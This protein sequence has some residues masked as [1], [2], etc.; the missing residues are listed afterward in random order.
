MA[1]F[2]FNA[3]DVP[4]DEYEL[5]PKGEYVALITDSEIKDTK[6][7]KMLVLTFNICEGA[8]KGRI[9]IERLNII[10]TSETAMKIA[11][12]QLAKI[13]TALDKKTF[14]DTT[15]LHNKRLKI[16]VDIEAGKGTYIAKDGTEKPRSDQNTI[17][18][19]LPMNAVTETS[20]QQAT[21]G[22]S[23]D[24]SPA[25]AAMPWKRS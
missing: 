2:D 25:K 4:A 15:E 6:S 11:R 23:T 10:N 18:A 1:Y 21:E 22:E 7:G 20:Q 9:L 14:K 24:L 12:Q 3:D 17:K 8:K 13:C 16:V 19:F 5:L